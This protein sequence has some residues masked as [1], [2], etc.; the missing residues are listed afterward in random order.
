MGIDFRIGS[1]SIKILMM[2]SALVVVRSWYLLLAFDDVIH[3]S[4]HFLL[5]KKEFMRFFQEQIWL[6]LIV[7]HA[8][9]DV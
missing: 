9:I 4:F 7:F 3:V 5:G 8:E 6:D 2:F 1:F